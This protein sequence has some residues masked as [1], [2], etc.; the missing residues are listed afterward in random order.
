MPTAAVDLGPLV[1]GGC[2]RG[3]H[4]QILFFQAQAAHS[5]CGVEG[6]GSR[7]DLPGD[8]VGGPSV[9]ELPDVG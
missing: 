8:G 2:G 3:K 5:G 1:Q 9:L 6:A 4:Y 7:E